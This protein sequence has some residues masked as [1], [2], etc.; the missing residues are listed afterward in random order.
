HG[1]G[2]APARRES[3]TDLAR[4]PA[5]NENERMSLLEKIKSHEARVVV[6]G[7]GY[8]GLPLSVEIARAGFTVTAFDKVEG[9][10]KSIVAGKSY[11]KDV[12]D[13]D[14]APL[15][16]AGK[17]DATTDPKVMGEADVIIICVPT[18]LNKT[19]DPDNSFIVDAAAQIVPRLRSGQLIILESTTF[20]GFTREI[21]KPQLESTG[22]SAG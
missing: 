17:L 6:I 11:I 9:K 3:P 20:P 21:L 15:V 7:A 8:V 12:R 22:L 13:D 16:K 19:K 14:L 18:P 5:R 2:R 10:C 4:G 1:R